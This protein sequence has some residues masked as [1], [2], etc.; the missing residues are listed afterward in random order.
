MNI[1]IIKTKHQK[2]SGLQGAIQKL[3]ETL[4]GRQ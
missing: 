4:G 1:L 2:L 3:R